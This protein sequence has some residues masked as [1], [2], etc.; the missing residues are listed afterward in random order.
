MRVKWN[1]QLDGSLARRQAE[2]EAARE[3]ANQQAVKEHK[4][5][6][7]LFRLFRRKKRKAPVFPGVPFAPSEP[8]DDD[9]CASVSS[10][11]TVASQPTAE[12]CQRD[13]TTSIFSS[14]RLNFPGSKKKSKRNVVDPEFLQEKE[15]SRYS[16]PD[17]RRTEKLL[18]GQMSSSSPSVKDAAR[19]RQGSEV[20]LPKHSST[21]CFAKADIKGQTDLSKSSPSVE[22][23]SNDVQMKMDIL[24][25]SH[26]E[27]SK[28]TPSVQV[29]SSSFK[30]IGN[31]FEQYKQDTSATDVSKSTSLVDNFLENQGTSLKETRK[32][33]INSSSMTISPVKD[34]GDLKSLERLRME[35]SYS[36]DQ[37]KC[38][39]KNTRSTKS[40]SFATNS[41]SPND[42]TCVAEAGVSPTVNTGEAIERKW[43]A[44]SPE[45]S[46]TSKLTSD[47]SAEPF[48]AVSGFGGIKE[49]AL[50]DAAGVCDTWNT[51][52]YVNMKNGDL[53][54]DELKSVC[55]SGPSTNSKCN[56]DHFSV[57][58]CDKQSNSELCS[59]KVCSY[60]DCKVVSINLNDKCEDPA[61][62]EITFS[63]NLCSKKPSKATSQSTQAINSSNK[64]IV[65]TEDVSAEVRFISDKYDQNDVEVCNHISKEF[66]NDDLVRVDEIKLEKLKSKHILDSACDERILLYTIPSK[67]VCNEELKSPCVFSADI[68]KPDSCLDQTVLDKNYLNLA[69]KSLNSSNFSIAVLESSISVLNDIENIESSLTGECKQEEYKNLSPNSYFVSNDVYKNP[70]S[71]K[72][73]DIKKQFYNASLEIQSTN[74][75]TDVVTSK[76]PFP[77]YSKCLNHPSLHT[78]KCD[79]CFRVNNNVTLEI[80]NNLR[81]KRSIYS[82]NDL[83]MISGSVFQQN[84]LCV[85]HS[86]AKDVVNFVKIRNK[87]DFHTQILQNN[88]DSTQINSPLPHKSGISKINKI[89]ISG[90]LSHGIQSSEFVPRNDY[91]VQKN[92]FYPFSTKRW[93]SDPSLLNSM[94]VCPVAT[95]HGKSIIMAERCPVLIPTTVTVTEHDLHTD[96]PQ[97]FDCGSG[98][99]S[100]L[101]KDN[102]ESRVGK[103]SLQPFCDVQSI[104]DIY[105]EGLIS[106]GRC[107]KN[108][109]E[110]GLQKLNGSVKNDVGSE[111]YSSENSSE[112]SEKFPEIEKTSV[113]S[114]PKTLNACVSEKHITDLPV[115]EY[116]NT[117]MKID[118]SNECIDT[119][120][121][122]LHC[123][124]EN[125]NCSIT[126]KVGTCSENSTLSSAPKMENN[127]DEDGGN[128]V[129]E[130]VKN[131]IKIFE[132]GPS[133]VSP[134]CTYSKSVLIPSNKVKQKKNCGK[135]KISMIPSLKKGIPV[136]I[137]SP[138]H[139]FSKEKDQTQ[140][141]RS[142]HIPEKTYKKEHTP[143]ESQHRVIKSLSNGKLSNKSEAVTKTQFDKNVKIQNET[144]TLKSDC[145]QPNILINK[146]NCDLL[147]YSYDG[148]H[149]T[150]LK[151]S[152]SEEQKDN[153]D[154]KINCTHLRSNSDCKHTDIL[155][156][157]VTIESHID[158]L[159]THI[160]TVENPS[161]TSEFPV[162]QSSEIHNKNFN[163]ENDQANDLITKNTIES[164]HDI[165]PKHTISEKEPINKTEHPERSQS[166][167]LLLNSITPSPISKTKASV[168]RYSS[169]AAFE[170]TADFFETLDKSSGIEDQQSDLASQSPLDEDYTSVSGLKT[171]RNLQSR[172]GSLPLVIGQV[173]ES[174]TWNNNSTV[175]KGNTRI[176]TK[177]VTSRNNSQLSSSKPVRPPLWLSKAEL[178]QEIQ[179]LGTLCEARTKELNRLKMETRHVTLGFDAFAS[180]FKYMV[181]DVNGLS[182][183]KLSEDLEKTLKQLELAKQDLAY[184]EKEVE[185]MKAHHCQELNDLSNKLFEVF[186][187][188]VTELGTKHQEEINRMKQE[189]EL[190][191]QATSETYKVGYEETRASHEAAIKKI[192]Q[193]LIIQREELQLFHEKELQELEQ[194]HC[195]SS[196]TLQEHIEQL[197][198]KCA[199]L[200]QHSLGMEDAMKKDTDSKLQ[201]VTSRKGD[202]EKEVESLKAV[203][204]M[205][206]KELHTLRVQTLEM[207]K[208]L[209]D[210]PLAREKIKMLTARAEDLEALMAEKTLRE[211]TLSTQNQTIR[212]TYEKESKV[213]KRLSMENE[214]LQW[215]L[216][217]AEQSLITASFSEVVEEEPGSGP[218]SPA[219]SPLQMSR[220]VFFTFVDR[221][222]ASPRSPYKKITPG[223]SSAYKAGSKSSAP[224]P[225]R[226]RGLSEPMQPSSASTPKRVPSAKKQR[227]RA[228]TESQSMAGSMVSSVGSECSVFDQKEEE[229]LEEHKEEIMKSLEILREQR[230]S[231]ENEESPVREEGCSEGTK[232]EEMGGQVVASE[233]NGKC[234]ASDVEPSV[235]MNC[236]K[237]MQEYSGQQQTI[238]PLDA[239]PTE[240]IPSQKDNEVGC[241]GEASVQNG[242]CSKDLIDIPYENKCN[243]DQISLKNRDSTTWYR[244]NSLEGSPEQTK[245]TITQNVCFTKSPN[246][247]GSD[248]VTPSSTSTSE[249]EEMT[250]STDFSDM[251]TYYHMTFP[252]LKEAEEGNKANI[253]AAQV[254]HSIV[255]SSEVVCQETRSVEVVSTKTIVISSQENGASM[256]VEKVS[257]NSSL[258]HS[259]CSFEKVQGS[260]CM[261][262]SQEKNRWRTM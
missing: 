192:E 193:E 210:L 6:P 69:N 131:K 157:F 57:G 18:E 248:P 108:G 49:D 95:S 175:R 125:E 30:V 120:P 167:E 111:L 247:N 35:N 251:K 104:C 117:E 180:L 152:T 63:E 101:L 15:P 20:V 163:S 14:F 76:Q 11:A 45:P 10:V 135:G 64:D 173:Q 127:I 99:V 241:T 169:A 252:V 3:A 153:Y 231:E 219:K 176:P 161:S 85:G 115:N 73:P 107:D 71:D 121:D 83:S 255:E 141:C 216:R 202:L 134:A 256:V 122:I 19:P 92:I 246:E 197:Q 48:Y 66:S 94:C 52:S 143:N 133:D 222:A 89:T 203:L 81:R 150:T 200:K 8:A 259:S 40:V 159:S 93:Y 90:N 47:D 98:N 9:D 82:L 4:E 29:A 68:R 96:T 258:S 232:M 181:E 215:R 149:C 1:R 204:E 242:S 27:I 236:Q 106:G 100:P 65:C 44:H 183:P 75:G 36:L 114:C 166:E 230:C 144:L 109:V 62:V 147:P 110:G 51:S 174:S 228:G 145:G 234:I 178:S 249:G 233:Q 184:Y 172:R 37:L 198:K 87:S 138:H 177:H 67:A 217:Q 137:K 213:N 239:S 186:H 199:E 191:L 60:G 28:S 162:K 34:S 155:N 5:S 116:V 205:K 195:E 240:D 53:H 187:G 151:R 260:E 13:R 38:A 220:S 226:G 206:N 208:Q 245:A 72:N 32:Q 188:E 154:S 257:Q 74:W 12:V 237:D 33:Y 43:L 156:H 84:L 179:R 112:I 250:R 142:Q 221:E 119:L 102:T 31:S 223:F 23:S 113:P 105:E 209:E 238:K 148:E 170:P 207:E 253:D 55:S 224:S 165:I 78:L 86:I 59:G 26:M 136:A 130:S 201:W 97:Y 16:S 61:S 25:N 21:N 190:Q 79:S 243:G 56:G 46:C 254:T 185:E 171:P 54:H 244:P 103:T 128:L 22:N 225:R 146:S 229:M 17:L 164:H 196:K 140:K 88:L 218:V 123:Q 39:P 118:L 50:S 211:R 42:V 24:N 2:E 158:H 91:L 261:D 182:V 70:S 189:H 132:N 124:S 235:E 194:K 77:E 58:L 168:R 214:E 212:D 41:L 262:E 227:Q 80:T 129:Y 139:Q 126:V 160:I 7:K